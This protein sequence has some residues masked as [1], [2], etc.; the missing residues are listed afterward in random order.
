LAI[1]GLHLRE[2]IEVEVQEVME[3]EAKED[4]FNDELGMLFS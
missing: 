3:Q 2:N 4:E 1:L